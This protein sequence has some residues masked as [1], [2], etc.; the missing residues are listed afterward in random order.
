M[1]GGGLGSGKDGSGPFDDAGHGPNALATV[2]AIN[3]TNFKN[4]V[5][6]QARHDAYL[7]CW[8]AMN[9]LQRRKTRRRVPGR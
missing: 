8:I 6:D 9:E 4:S 7:E 2:D 1:K 5:S 3:Y